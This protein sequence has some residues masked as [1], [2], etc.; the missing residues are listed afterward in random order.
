MQKKPKRAVVGHRNASRPYHLNKVKFKEQIIL[1]PIFC[2]FFSFLFLGIILSCSPDSKNKKDKSEHIYLE[3]LSL[4]YNENPEKALLKFDESLQLYSRH[5]N[6]RLMK[7]ATLMLLGKEDDALWF[8]F[9]WPGQLLQSFQKDFYGK[10]FSWQFKKQIELCNEILSNHKK[11]KK[12]WIIHARYLRLW[13]RIGQVEHWMS[14][15]DQ[16]FHLNAALQSIQKALDFDPEL[17]EAWF[18]KAVIHTNLAEYQQAVDCISQ[19]KKINPNSQ[20]IEEFS[21]FVKRRT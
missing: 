19:I 1:L 16:A 2:I 10:N 21:E 18:E 13:V 20:Y 14:R 9:G 3:G 12:L 5:K 11:L 17:E 8:Y 4:L 7:A 15:N 6:A